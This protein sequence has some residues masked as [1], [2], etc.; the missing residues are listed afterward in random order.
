M[1]E[2][3][4]YRVPGNENALLGLP[5][6]K[7]TLNSSFNIRNGLSVNPSMIYLSDRYGYN[8][9][10]VLDGAVL[11][12]KDPLVQA[13]L[14]INYQNMFTKG[15]DVGIGVYNIFDSELDFIQA[16]NGGHAPLPGSSREIIFRL[17]YNFNFKFNK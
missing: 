6:H 13:N 3:P 10:R 5:Q 1:N 15:L 9:D 12:K 2:V 17:S 4:I 11:T 14:F 8:Y 7:I 16:Y